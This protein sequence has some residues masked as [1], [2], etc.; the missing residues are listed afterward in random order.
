ME[1]DLCL[2][3]PMQIA[4]VGVENLFLYNIIYKRYE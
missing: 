4:L 3:T 2:I 1:Q